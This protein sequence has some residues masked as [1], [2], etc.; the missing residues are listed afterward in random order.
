MLTYIFISLFFIQNS[1]YTYLI[2]E[3][4]K[5]PNI[6]MILY[7]QRKNITPLHYHNPFS[8]KITDR[9]TPYQDYGTL[10]I[11]AN[12]YLVFP[13]DSL[14]VKRYVAFESFH[15]KELKENEWK[16]YVLNYFSEPLTKTK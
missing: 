12:G 14:G 11:D 15:S 7:D 13:H 8:L 3:N 10:E 9:V 16:Q 1:I 2:K 4:S 5:Y 6:S